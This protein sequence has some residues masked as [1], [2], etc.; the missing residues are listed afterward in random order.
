MYEES[1]GYVEGINCFLYA[2]C[3]LD[4]VLCN[5]FGT[6]VPFW[7]ANSKKN[8]FNCELE[9]IGYRSA[10]LSSYTNRTHLISTS[11]LLRFA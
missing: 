6:R 1:G 2:H 7:P 10:N 9:H 8:V 5:A 3:K 4:L 11:K